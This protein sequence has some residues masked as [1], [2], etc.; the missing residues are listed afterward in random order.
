MEQTNKTTIKQSNKKTQNKV[1][2]NNQNNNQ[3][4]TF[5]KTVKELKQVLTKDYI[6]VNLKE[7]P[8][9]KN[10]NSLNKKQ[11]EYVLKQYSIFPKHIVS[12]LETVRNKS[13]DNKFKK[14]V[15]ELTRNIGEELGTQTHGI[16]HYDLLIQG[17]KEEFNLNISKIDSEESTF[18]FLAN[19]RKTFSNKNIFHTLG[20]IYATELSA[21]PELLIVYKLINKYSRIIKSK[22][23]D[24]G[25]LKSFFDM[26]ISV[27]EPGHEQELYK[28]C[29]NYVKTKED[30]EEFEKGFKEVLSTMDVWWTGLYNELK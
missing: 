7:N 28:A 25:M 1:Q 29:K 30:L 18:Q 20:A 5:N 14:I 24:D 26:H 13:E 6:C 19:M 27:W 11:I 16:T 15:V 23:I 8:F 9:S 10:I 4:N 12:F 21:K 17:V 2:K 22:K 3:N